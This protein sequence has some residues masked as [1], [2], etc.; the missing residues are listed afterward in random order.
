MR[1]QPFEYSLDYSPAWRF[2]AR[3][4]RWSDHLE[5]LADKYVRKTLDVADGLPTPFVGTFSAFYLI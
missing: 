4:M 1:D 3:Y 2:S 5:Q